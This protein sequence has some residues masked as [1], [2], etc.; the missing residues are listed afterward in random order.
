MG[1]FYRAVP[2]SVKRFSGPKHVA[3]KWERVSGQR[4][5]EKQELKAYG[6]ELKDRDTL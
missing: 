1:V 6:A 3:R 2:E 4:H 5:A